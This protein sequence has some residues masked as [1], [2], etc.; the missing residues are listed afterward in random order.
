MQRVVSW[1]KAILPVLGG[2]A[3]WY[4]MVDAPADKLRNIAGTF[5]AVAGTLMGFM[6][7]ALSILTAM[8]NRRLIANLRQTGHYNR[9]L[10]ELFLASAAYLVTLILALVS[11]FLSDAWV[12]QSVAL[13]TAAMI[14][15]TVLFVFAG[16]KFTLVMK[17]LH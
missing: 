16:H 7:A 12:L 5:A 11:L 17:H 3:V 14:A 2:L 15:A 8:V 9:L 10:H 4:F 6:I 1:L 13:A